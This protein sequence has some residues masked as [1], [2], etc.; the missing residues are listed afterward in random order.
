L[1]DS[2][3]IRREISRLYDKDPQGWRV[4]VGKDRLGFYD[5]LISHGTQ[6]WQVKEYQVNPYKFVGLG[7]RLPSLTPDSL[8]SS[9]HPFGFRPVGFKQMKELAAVIDDPRAVSELAGKLLDKKPVSS[10]EALES[11]GV[12]HGPILHSSRPLEAISS[13]HTKLDEKLRK[14]LQRIVN[15]DFRHTV[16]PYI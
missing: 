2:T 8:F 3:K 10:T 7:S 5:V 9:E 6:A 11:P 13:S 4:L 12:L 16:A 14:E 15:R 1:L